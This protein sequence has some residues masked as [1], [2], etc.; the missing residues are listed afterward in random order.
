LQ[1]VTWVQWE[2]NRQTVGPMV[3]EEN[4]KGLVGWVDGQG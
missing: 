2:S 3:E 4:I 1:A